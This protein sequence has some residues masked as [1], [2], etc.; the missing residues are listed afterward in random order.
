MQDAGPIPAGLARLR[1]RSGHGRF[2]PHR[3]P[4]ERV[5]R[6]GRAEL[7]VSMTAASEVNL[8]KRRVPP[9]LP[10][11]LLEAV[12]AQDRP[13]EVLEDEDVTV[14]LPR[15]LGLSGV[16]F[17]QIRRYE[18]AQS[19][20]RKIPMPEFVGLLRLVMRRH[21]AAVILHETGRRYARWRL[22]RR[23]RTAV[24]ALHT[25]PARVMF[26]GAR[27]AARRV[28][29]GMTGDAVSAGRPFTIRI[30]DS[31]IASLGT[32]ACALYTGALEELVLQYGGKPRPIEH[33]ACEARGEQSCEWKVVE[34]G[35]GAS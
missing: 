31:T 13:G 26:L 29:R 7:P 15:R 23:R 11:A 16:V 28:L 25:L 14:S 4:I 2:S 35:T 6:A 22:E 19:K 1:P 24:V 9:A 17:D 12:R 10:L 34:D 32:G 5:D 8:E 20:G 18:E 27:R 30:D 3:R 21:D 33:R